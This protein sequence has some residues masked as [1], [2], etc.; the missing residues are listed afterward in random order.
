[1]SPCTLLRSIKQST[2]VPT[3]FHELGNQL[4]YFRGAVSSFFGTKCP[5]GTGIREFTEEMERNRQVFMNATTTNHLS[6][7]KV[8]STLDFRPQRWLG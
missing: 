8:L 3:Q 1:M 4:T 6:C 2:M 7:A 5:L